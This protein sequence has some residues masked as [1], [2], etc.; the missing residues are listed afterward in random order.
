[1]S[2]RFRRATRACQAAVGVALGI[3]SSA[4]IASASPLFE[5]AGGVQG[6]AG[7]NAR[8]YEG[9]A[10]NAYFNPAFLPSAEAG[11][12]LGVFVLADEI[13]IRGAARPAGSDIPIAAAGATFPNDPL[14]HNGVPTRWLERG[15]TEP[16]IAARPR[17]AGGSGH[18]LRTYQVIGLVHKFFEGRLAL[19]LYGMIPYGTFTSAA[20]FYSDER[21]QYFS[22]SLHYELY[23]DRL[24]A[25]SIAF[26]TGL[27]LTDKLSL[28]LAAT[29]GLKATAASPAYLKS[30]G[31]FQDILLD[32]NVSVNTSLTPHFG[33]VYRPIDRWN[34]SATVHTPQKFEVDA[35]FKFLVVTGE[36]NGVDEGAAIGFTHSYLP[37]KISLG[38]SF[39]VVRTK[40]TKLAVVGTALYADWSTYVDRHNARPSDAYAWYDTLSGTLGARFE[41]GPLRALLDAAYEPS[42]VPDQTGRT[43]YVDNDRIAGMA[44]F[45]YSFKFFSGKLRTGLQMQVHRLLPRRTTKLAEYS[46]GMTRPDLV[47]DEVPDDATA[48]ID[49]VTGSPR[50][51]GGREGLQTNNPGWPGFFSAGWILGGSLHV[52]FHY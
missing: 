25:T 39:D 49:P 8:S 48:G 23:S 52:T 37:W 45:D 4:R 32:A 2:C 1:M 3:V 7:F 21:E 19:G 30:I 29:L 12:E 24:T 42:P 46:Q 11:F 9:G 33:A 10:A 51:L 47:I 41:H 14:P 18:N 43:N 44:G 5:L 15:S 35:K 38:S 31:A 34:L 16:L 27:Q 28:G 50:P 6:Q 26:A 40:E 17:Q 22:N 20:A 13:G 36:N